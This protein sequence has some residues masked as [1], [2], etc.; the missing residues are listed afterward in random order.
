MTTPVHGMLAAGSDGAPLFPGDE[1]LLAAGL[2]GI[3]RDLDPW[4]AFVGDAFR[5]RSF[6]RA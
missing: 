3:E 5:R 2:D 4:P 1:P 6:E